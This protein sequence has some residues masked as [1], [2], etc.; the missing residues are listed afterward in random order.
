MPIGPES[1]F[2]IARSLTKYTVQFII[3]G[4]VPSAAAE[5]D[6]CGWAKCALGFR[7][8]HAQCKAQNKQEYK[9]GIQYDS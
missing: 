7:H 5:A 8:Y 6:L 3:Q 4:Y 2:I 9:T 1:M